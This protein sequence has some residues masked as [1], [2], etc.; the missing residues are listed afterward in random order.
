MDFEWDETKSEWTQCV[1]G[2]D[3]AVAA[4]IFEGTVQT[5][6]DD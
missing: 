6:V 4:R 5:V 2:F 1:R 3:F